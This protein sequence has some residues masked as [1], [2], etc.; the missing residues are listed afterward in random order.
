MTRFLSLTLA[1]AASLSLVAPVFSETCPCSAS[2]STEPVNFL[3]IHAPSVALSTQIQPNDSALVAS[4]IDEQLRINQITM[5]VFKALPLAQ[6]RQVLSPGK[7]LFIS[8]Q[9]MHAIV[10]KRN[11]VPYDVRKNLVVNQTLDV[12]TIMRYGVSLPETLSM[13]MTQVPAGYSRV[14]IGNHL[15][16]LDGQNTITDVTPVK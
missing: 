7:H 12:P 8:R 1:I 11:T 14:L 15:V 2:E 3:A 10:P 9:E 5:D 13:A 6:Q 16:M 4:Y